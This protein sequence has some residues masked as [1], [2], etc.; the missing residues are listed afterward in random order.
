MSNI[1]VDTNEL[2]K[3][4]KLSSEHLYLYSFAGGIGVEKGGDNQIQPQETKSLI[5]NPEQDKVI[6]ISCIERKSY[7]EFRGKELISQNELNI[8]LSK[9][10]PD[11]IAGSFD[12]RM[13]KLFLYLK[14]DRIEGLSKGVYRINPFKS[15]V[16]LLNSEVD[17]KPIFNGSESIYESSGFAIILT[18]D[19]VIND[20]RKDA[21]FLTGY[22]GQN[23]M[24]ISTKHQIGLCAIGTV[25][26]SYSKEV[27]GLLENEEVLHS[28][29]GGRVLNEQIEKI[30]QVN[31][32]NNLQEMLAQLKNFL[33]LHIPVYMV[34]NHFVL[35]ERFPLTFNGKIDRKALPD[36]IMNIGRNY[37]APSNEN[38]ERLTELWSE[39][40]DLKK[41]IVSVNTSFFE[42]GGNSI[43]AIKI[44]N[45]IKNEFKVEIKLR[46][47]Y[48]DP[49]IKGISEVIE[50]INFNLGKQVDNQ[51]FE[52]VIL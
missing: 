27:L 7:R 29:L 24:N 10:I 21:F 22:V 44:I 26:Q 25:N 6:R 51:K 47:F 35:L 39:E 17:G 23:I 52:E 34:P 13:I 5:K 46:N 45:R 11:G 42:L 2:F 9:I 48:D 28:F 41:E 43:N 49:T 8:I 38:E 3:S 18:G 33:K 19:R 30:E 31:E 14:D 40:L 50:T 36:P 1:T 20:N 32:S 4:F 15:S 37:V 12:Q 16:E